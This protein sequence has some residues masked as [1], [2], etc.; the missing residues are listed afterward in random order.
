[1]FITR[2]KLYLSY[3]YM[4]SYLL[5]LLSSVIIIIF[6][7]YYYNWC[8]LL[9]ITTISYYYY[10]FMFVVLI[11]FAISELITLGLYFFVSLC[12]LFESY[13]Y[14]YIYIYYQS[15]EN[16]IYNDEFAC[17]ND[18][19]LSWINIIFLFQTKK[20]FWICNVHHI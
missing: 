15:I 14:I 3:K 19:Y 2:K 9:F 18:L 8:I 5:L 4:V 6:D 13:I 12:L 11:V 17:L 10:L 7:C 20:T 1:M 16:I